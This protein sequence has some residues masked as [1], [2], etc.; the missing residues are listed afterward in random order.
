MSSVKRIYLDANG[1]APAIPEA[2]DTIKNIV[3]AIGNPSSSHDHGR[4][5]RAL[6][7][8][9][10]E[11]VAQALDARAKEIVFTCGASESN[12]LFVDA[13]HGLADRW[14][15][16]LRVVMSPYE[17]P[18]LHKPIMHDAHR[19]NVTIMATDETGA[20]VF[21][22]DACAD[23][24]VFIMCHAHNETGIIND[25]DGF[26]QKLSPATL[27]M[28]DISQ[29]FARHTCL[30]SRIDVMTFS[31]QKMGGFAGAGGLLLRG[32][33]K[34]LSAPWLGGGQER[35]FRPGTE[36]TLAIAAMGTAA[37]YIERSR[38]RSR[39]QIELRDYF[40]QNIANNAPVKILGARTDRLPNTSA[41]CFYEEDADA[42]RI[43]CD[44]AGLSVGFGAACSGLAPEGSFALKR[45][46]LSRAHERATVR[47]SFSL[48][49]TQRD[50]D[51]TIKR[52]LGS[53]LQHRL[54]T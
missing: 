49:T 22:A 18:S 33:G 48:E 14:E 50:I 6:I 45:L 12:R 9:A 15:R 10:R 38:E 4:V 24:D 37:Q 34:K 23:I 30:S 29:A 26:A 41:V 3:D 25:V 47:F 43:A 36:N 21:D 54:S 7:D 1:S 17:H 52:L 27:V 2:K 35:G 46:G 28:S 5:M 20:L 19:L 53:V 16:P 51:E 39:R 42:L 32:N 11:Q 13:L 40:E 44:L 31:A 8:D